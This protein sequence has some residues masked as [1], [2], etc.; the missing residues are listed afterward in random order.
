MDALLPDASSAASSA[1]GI[2]KRGLAPSLSNAALHSQT[3]SGNGN[4]DAAS[5]ALDAVGGPRAVRRVLPTSTAANTAATTGANASAGATAGVN[6]RS[7]AS[8]RSTEQVLFLCC[9]LVLSVVFWSASR[10]C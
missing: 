6:G 8:S 7:L 1:A 5:A 9:V 4:G 10:S 2:L 3:E